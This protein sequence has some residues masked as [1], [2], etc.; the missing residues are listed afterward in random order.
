MNRHFNAA[1]DWATYIDYAKYLA[2]TYILI[3]VDERVY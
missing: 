1:C 2:Y 3:L